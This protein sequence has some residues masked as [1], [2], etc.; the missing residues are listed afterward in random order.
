MVGVL[1]DFSMLPFHSKNTWNS[2]TY[3]IPKRKSTT[4]IPT[5]SSLQT[6]KQRKTNLSWSSRPTSDKENASPI[7]DR[8]KM[9][10]KAKRKDK[11]LIKQKIHKLV[12]HQETIVSP[13][14]VSSIALKHQEIVPQ[15][16][17]SSNAVKQPEAVSHQSASSNA[18]KPEVA[19][20][21]QHVSVPMSSMLPNIDFELPTHLKDNVK[22]L[23]ALWNC[24]SYQ[25]R[26]GW[27]RIFTNS[28]TSHKT[29]VHTA[30]SQ[31][32]DIRMYFRPIILQSITKYVKFTK[33]RFDPMTKFEKQQIVTAIVYALYA[34]EQ[35]QKVNK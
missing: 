26:T 24:A 21:D 9:K 35:K 12:K 18:V 6:K 17:V 31:I 19:A 29:V 13:Q 1:H 28:S 15:Q 11:Q 14:S 25:T 8:Q 7:A 16:S 33:V 32:N 4:D 10:K 34:H 30:T 2:S 22:Q 27:Y 3:R 23:T 5:Q 20:S